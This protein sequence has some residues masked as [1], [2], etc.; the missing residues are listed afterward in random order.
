MSDVSRSPSL[1]S[2]EREMTAG[3]LWPRFSLPIE[4][5]YRADASAASKKPVIGLW[6]IGIFLFDM[7]LISDYVVAPGDFVLYATCRLLILTPACLASLYLAARLP[8]LYNALVGTAPV[9]MS[10]TLAFL[11]IVTHGSYRADYLFGN[12]LILIC[13]CVI[14]RTPLGYAIVSVLL[15]CALFEIVLFVSDIDSSAGR[16]LHT[17]FCISGATVALITS[18]ALERD[19]RQAFLM[20][21]RVRLLNR[22]LEQFAMTDPLTGLANRRRLAEATDEVWAKRPASD[23][24]A[25]IVLLDIDH[26]K[27]FNDHH[28]HMAGDAC[29]QVIARLVC[30]HL[31]SRDLAVRFGGE[32]ILVFLPD[33]GFAAAREVAEAICGSIRAARLAHPALGDQAIVT[34]SLGV[35]AAN[36]CDCTVNEVIAQAD[37]ALYA[38]KAGGRNRVHPTASTRSAFQEVPAG[39]H[40]SE[41][42]DER[43][44]A[45]A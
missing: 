3:R 25:S 2:I 42:D 34:A 41:A 13:G 19:L 12:V 32:E 35:H 5:L 20:G 26:F 30:K 21:L 29:L 31:R 22:E 7:F 9:L 44:A 6:L 38:A 10:A 43:M 37:A 18:Y 45:L 1:A 14:N 24:V 15:Q 11:L 39:A 33:T 28:G 27:M 40:R 36:P 23:A 16:L 4:C 17:L 8:G